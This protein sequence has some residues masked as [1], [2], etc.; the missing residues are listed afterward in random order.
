MSW[1][2]ENQQL[3]SPSWQWPAHHLVLVKNFLAKNNVTTLHHPP[4]SPDLLQ[5]IFICSLEWN[6]HG[7]VGAFVMLLTSLRMWWNEELK[8]YKNGFQECF[9]QFY[10]VLVEMYCV[11]KISLMW[12]YCFVFFRNKVI[13]GTLWSYHVSEINKT[14]GAKNTDD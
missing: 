9:Q 12:L 5:L 10:N 14:Q 2:M 1:K 3:V 4:Y 6:Q 7:R 11:T 13:P 8:G